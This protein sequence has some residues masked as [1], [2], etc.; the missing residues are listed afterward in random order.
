MNL[1]PI[2]KLEQV[3]QEFQTRQGIFTHGRTFSALR[4]VTLSF[5][6][7]LF[8][9]LAGGS[10]SGKTTLARLL[11][12]LSEPTGGTILFKGQPLAAALRSRKEPYWHKVQMIF[13]NP[14]QSLD[15]KWK[16]RQIVEEGLREMPSGIRLQKA[17][18]SLEKVGLKTAYLDRK[19]Q[20][21]S[22][23]ERQRVAIARALAVKP[24][25][26]ILDE[27]TSQ[28]D[29]SVQAQ[30]LKLLLDLRPELPGGMLFITHD[31]A[32]VSRLADRLVILSSG[33]VVEEG[34]T[35]EVL[36]KPQHEATRSLI[37]AIPA[38]KK[39]AAEGK[40]A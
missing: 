25:F 38:W 13:Q 14:Y 39:P 37:A 34:K 40:S 28:L 21:L 6:S 36:K 2:F 10:G 32:L 29:V 23:G 17:G 19:P 33:V 12:G 26:L 31:L 15:P 4:N 27:P 20:A 9:G 16:I 1:D 18:E 24:D 8:Y 5:S 35:L 11:A 3:S 7:G 22:G 30:I